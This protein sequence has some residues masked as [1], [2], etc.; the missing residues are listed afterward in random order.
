[1]ATTAI[2]SP[3]FPAWKAQQDATAELAGRRQAATTW[4]GLEN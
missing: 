1:L 2:Q 4:K 3:P